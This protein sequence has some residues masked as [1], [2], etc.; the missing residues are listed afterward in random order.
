MLMKSAQLNKILTLGLVLLAQIGM[1]QSKKAYI[2]FADEAF[3]SKDYQSA[4]TFY[5]EALQFDSSNL[6]VAYQAAESARLFNAY[7]KAENLYSYVALNQKNR[8]YPKVYFWIAD[9]QQRQGKYDQSLESYKLY[10]SENEMPGDWFTE[11]S[12]KEILAVEWAKSLTQQDRADVEIE[13][14]GTDINTPY[15]EFGA[16][17]IND[18]L[19]YS[20][21]RFETVVDKNKP[22]VIFSRLLK[23]SGDS[24]SVFASL[25][26][27]PQM[28]A[29]VAINSK[30]DRFYYT[31][32]QYINASDI[33]CKLYYRSLNN[34]VWSE[35]MPLPD[36]IN[37]DTATATQPTLGID[38]ITQNEIL[39]FTSDRDGGKGGLDIWASMIEKDGS[40]Q[41]PVNLTE[42]NTFYD[43]ITPFYHRPTGTLYFSSN[44][45]RGF[46]GFDVYKSN[47]YSG[48]WGKI[49]HLGSEINTSYN[50]I[51]FSLSDDKKEGYLSSN[52]TGSFFLEESIE[53]CCYDIY[54]AKFNV[55]DIK[56]L[57]STFDAI[58]REPLIGAK[59]IL[60]NLT[61]PGAD[62]VIIENF[63]GNDFTFPLESDH[64]YAVVAHKDGF[65]RDSVLFNTIGIFQNQDIRKNL[66]LKSEK[67]DL[68]VSTF[69]ALK[70]L[71][72]NGV[73]VTLIDL[74]DPTVEPIIVT[75]DDN[76]QFHFPLLRGKKYMIVAS[77]KGYEPAS[78]E[79][80]TKDFENVN[81][82]VRKLYL[83]IGSLE[84]FLP[85]ILFFEN[86]YPDPKSTSK[87]TSSS[88]SDLYETYYQAKAQYVQIYSQGGD[89][90]ADIQTEY[91]RFFENRLKVGYDDLNKFLEQLLL[92][93]QNGENIEI[94][95][96]GYTSPRSSAGYNLALGQRRV[97]NVRNEIDRF[98]NGVLKSYMASGQFKIEEKSFGETTSP[99]DVSDRINDPRMSIYSIPA[100]QERRVEIVQ[101]KR[102]K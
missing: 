88:Y 69:D 83:K 13:H 95:L 30:K 74:S 36:Y 35:P 89:I 7:S 50:D 12:R 33:R 8:E 67:L 25:P 77:K 37:L 71:P 96:K 23:Q 81:T 97:V 86:D 60:Y 65:T 55:L 3:G 34:G 101:I 46:G 20:S 90:T 62:P 1:S 92:N 11:K 16:L 28:E 42:I 14:L 18:T 85:L 19:W 52:R 56:L 94:S 39:Y 48:G 53:A 2:K 75:N 40:F 70:Q 64:E 102:N 100:A 78:L 9:V 63:Q 38:P 99:K 31:V 66:F 24:T 72:L 82:I 68:D 73:A 17:K 98:Q 87:T 80:D 54:K 61:D 84:S 76:N 51:Y 59:V 43:E 57:A 6:A 21:L 58:S 32:C 10:L 29:H 27:L 44:G 47:R 22:P 41:N 15:S 49:E 45:Q 5:E 93:L 79:L 26:A 91:D 4:M